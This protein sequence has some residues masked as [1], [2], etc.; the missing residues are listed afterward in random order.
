MEAAR[1]FATRIVREGGADVRQRVAWAFREALGREPRTDEAATA[2][3]LFEKHS[4]SYTNDPK[5]AAAILKVGLAPL[6]KDANPSE[7]AAWTSVARVI[8]NL[9][10]TITRS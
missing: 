9:H 4:A 2:V 5:A 1:A 10:E 7:L 6:P 3:A 8:L